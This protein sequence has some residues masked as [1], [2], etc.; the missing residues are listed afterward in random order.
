[1]PAGLLGGWIHLEKGACMGCTGF[2]VSVAFGICHGCTLAEEEHV[3][4][5]DRV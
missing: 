4:L 1:M 3:E 2:G 5:E